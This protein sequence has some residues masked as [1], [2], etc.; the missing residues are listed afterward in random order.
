MQSFAIGGLA[1]WAQPFFVRIHD[2]GQKEAA[3]YTSGIVAGAGFVGT[4][5]GA[6]V[7]EF[8]A[9][10]AR[11]PAYALVTAV[12]YFVAAPLLLAGL[13]IPDKNL[14]LG[15]MFLGVVGM[16]L[17]TGPSNAIVSARAPALHRATAFALLIV[18]LH[19]LGDAPSPVI[20][21]ALSDGLRARGMPEGAALQKAL[22]LAPVAL[23]LAS[24]CMVICAW[25]ARRAKP[26]D[27]AERA[28]SAP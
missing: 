19:V 12:G 11:L 7:A 20:V 18:L 8:F 10:R 13:Y 28:A 25:A 5:V 4:A 14:A 2:M 3:L 27:P 21:G 6:L 26:I 17:G 23:L 22:M 16:F 24:A 9:K 1:Q 15:C